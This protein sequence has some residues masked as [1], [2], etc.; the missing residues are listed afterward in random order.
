MLGLDGKMHHYPSGGSFESFPKEGGRIE[1]LVKSLDGICI[2]NECKDRLSLPWV[3]AAVAFSGSASDMEVGSSSV[4]G[5]TGQPIVESEPVIISSSDML[6]KSPKFSAE[7]TENGTTQPH[8]RMQFSSVGREWAATSLQKGNRGAKFF[9]QG[10]DS[11][12]TSST[13]T[14]STVSSSSQR[15]VVGYL[16]ENEECD[17]RSWSDS[18]DTMPEIV[19]MYVRLRH[20][21]EGE[22][23]TTWDGVAFL[24]VYGH[25][26]DWGTHLVELPIRPTVVGKC[27]ELDYAG[28]I[29][30][31]C[32]S[33]SSRR[34]SRMCLSG[35][36][37]LTV[38]VKVNPCRPTP[39]ATASSS[40]AVSGSTECPEVELSRS[41]IE[42]KLRPILQ[43]LRQSEEL[44][45]K[46]CQSQ[47][48]AMDVVVPDSSRDSP[49]PDPPPSSDN[50]YYFPIL[51]ELV[52][53]LSHM[54]SV[55]A[56]CDTGHDVDSVNRDENSTI[57]TRGSI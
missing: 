20:G 37:T 14:E 45:K 12:C 50:L 43:K 19:E 34:N 8:L 38:Q 55:T 18:G 1:V 3:T 53:F 48:R 51:S 49:L 52:S 44:A 2:E 54:V 10:L 25:E 22:K 23:A 17:T 9:K 31:T 16:S 26:D 40:F 46:L 36:A 41:A 42:D 13:I 35:D 29:L 32:S 30:S 21:E 56:P 15:D 33:S 7:W 11:A 28:T 47:R 4:C 5:I 27:K 39:S 6:S 57:A 24:V